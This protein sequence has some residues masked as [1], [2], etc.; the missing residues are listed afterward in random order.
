MGCSQFLAVATVCSF[1]PRKNAGGF[2]YA[3]YSRGAGRNLAS[4]TLSWSRTWVTG[5]V[6]WLQNVRNVNWMEV[7]VLP[8]LRLQQCETECSQGA[9]MAM[10]TV[11]IIQL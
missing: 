8:P 2:A 10:V 4:P 6:C 5:S 1:S 9:D 7:I 3:R 11:V